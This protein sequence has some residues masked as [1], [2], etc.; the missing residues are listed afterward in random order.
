M[1]GPRFNPQH[2]VILDRGSRLWFEL[3]YAFL[4]LIK[5]NNLHHKKI[6][7]GK[8]KYYYYCEWPIGDV[9]AGRPTARWGEHSVGPMSRRDEVGARNRP[10]W[11]LYRNLGQTAVTW[12]PDDPSPGRVQRPSTFPGQS[13]FATSGRLNG[14]PRIWGWGRAHQKS[15][16]GV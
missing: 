9:L 2:G 12:F 7:P 15:D 4:S 6:D 5:K 3:G 14:P 13:G 1:K 16:W 8:N 11:F 10:R